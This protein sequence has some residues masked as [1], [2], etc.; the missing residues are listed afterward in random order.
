MSSSRRGNCLRG[1]SSVSRSCVLALISRLLLI[2]AVKAVL[3]DVVDD[4]VWDVVADALAPLP[5]E[6]DLGG[7]HVVLDEL[8]N[9][10]NVVAELLEAD[11]RVV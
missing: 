9:H 8:W 2:V 11:K 4:L 7:G 6:A 10:A 3:V 1:T 5:E